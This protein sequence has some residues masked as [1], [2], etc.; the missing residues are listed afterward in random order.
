MLTCSKLFF[1]L[2]K[3]LQHRCWAILWYFSST[4]FTSST[5]QEMSVWSH[6]IVALHRDQLHPEITCTPLWQTFQWERNHELKAS[7]CLS[8][9]LKEDRQNSDVPTLLKKYLTVPAQH[10]PGLWKCVQLKHADGFWV[11]SS[12]YSCLL[13]LY[14]SQV[15]L[16]V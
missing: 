12:Q 4:L 2:L 9:L 3:S 10:V 6:P 15:G 14:I 8:H 5:D 16:C 13:P 1:F 7:P 11:V